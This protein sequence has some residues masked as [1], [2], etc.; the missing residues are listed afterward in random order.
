VIPYSV[1]LLLQNLLFSSFLSI[2]VLLAMNSLQQKRVSVD[3]GRDLRDRPI[4]PLERRHA[5][6]NRIASG[7]PRQPFQGGGGSPFD[8]IERRIRTRAGLLTSLDRPLTPA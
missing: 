6:G 7:A 5:S 8:S 3:A 2:D 4:A 1:V